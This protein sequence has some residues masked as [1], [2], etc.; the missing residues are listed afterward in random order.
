MQSGNP[1]VRQKNNRWEATV[2]S[3]GSRVVKPLRGI[4]RGAKPLDRRGRRSKA[5]RQPGLAPAPV[6]TRTKQF[7]FMNSSRD[8]NRRA[9]SGGPPNPAPSGQ[10]PEAGFL[11]SPTQYPARD[12][13]LPAPSKP[14]AAEPGKMR[15]PPSR[16]FYRLGDSRIFPMSLLPDS[17][18]RVS[19]I[20]E[21][22][23]FI[24]ALQ[25]VKSEA[26]Y[27]RGPYPCDF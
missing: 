21:T 1:S 25:V 13:M 27:S 3:P 14:G 2:R 12:G 11:L 9:D 19:P 4:A 15:L 22:H 6:R 23:R 10:R 20:L 18:I 17:I 24:E 8:G 7:F 5:R 16:F 26:P